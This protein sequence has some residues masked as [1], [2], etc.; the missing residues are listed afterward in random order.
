M[1]KMQVRIEGRVYD[2]QGE[3][4]PGAKITLLEVG[5][6]VTSREDGRYLFDEVGLEEGEYA[7]Q[8]SPPE[9]YQSPENQ[10][11]KIEVGQ[12][13][14]GG[15]DFRCTPAAML[16]EASMNK[17]NQHP[18][19]STGDADFDLKQCCREITEQLHAIAIS[20]SAANIQQSGSAANIQ[21][22]CDQLSSAVRDIATF[23]PT[24][25]ESTGGVGGGGG[26]TG[27][28]A[29]QRV[30][31]VVAQVL[32]RSIGRDPKSFMAALTAAFPE[33]KDGQI[34]LEPVRA[35]VSLEVERGQLAASQGTLFREV[36]LIVNDALKILDG[37]HS[38]TF[39]TDKEKAEAL[40]EIVR[41]E[42]SSLIGEA[43]RV[44]RPRKSRVD[45]IFAQLG[46]PI[47]MS[48]QTGGHLGLLRKELGLD[49]ED[50]LLTESTDDFLVT[51]EEAQQVASMNLLDQY[52]GTLS[53]S[54]D[55]FFMTLEGMDPSNGSFS[56][57]LAFVSTLF[58]VVAASVREV[59]ADMDAVE[60]SQAERRTAFI[61]DPTVP[62][63]DASGLETFPFRISINSILSWVED[64]A[65]VEGPDLIAKSGLIGLTRVIGIVT[66]RLEPLVGELLEISKGAEGR[67]T[68]NL[69]E[70]SPHPGLTHSRVRNSLQQLDNQ[71]KEFVTA[72]PPRFS[73]SS[74]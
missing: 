14:I 48:G 7:I 37:L 59:E 32:G 25:A 22:C 23:I 55:T 11:I 47:P 9:G 40:T 20:G 64:F 61:L 57:R 73:G 66:V 17:Q 52:A 36:Q 41:S 8:C 60:L 50:V 26:A 65:S 4:I 13:M 24:K 6:Q 38:I 56:G 31:K 70:S 12:E 42:F 72:L 46:T 1:A 27:S 39:E 3:P 21:Q 63:E 19:E 15:V 74:R 10:S 71:L 2:H 18:G 44:D 54:F 16:G 5:E 62:M 34:V 49:L 69:R 51:S 45:E 28:F 35:V 53:R 68:A 29:A 58:S 43:G 67:P 30:S 33:G